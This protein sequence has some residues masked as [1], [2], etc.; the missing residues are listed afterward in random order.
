M[1]LPELLSPVIGIAGVLLLGLLTAV[2]LAGKQVR[3]QPVPIRRGPSRR[4]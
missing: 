2:T 1:A 4:H 3:P